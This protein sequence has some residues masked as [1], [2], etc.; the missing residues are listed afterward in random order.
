MDQQKQLIEVT[1]ISTG[2]TRMYHVT[3][4]L[5]SQ[6]NQIMSANPFYV[7]NVPTWISDEDYRKLS[8]KFNLPNRNEPENR[9]IES[10]A[11]D[12]PETPTADK[13][14]RQRKPKQAE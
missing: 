8:I 14:K 5:G 2:K 6:G 1:F 10:V 13:P 4:L 12:E 9:N 11:G 3:V 7:S